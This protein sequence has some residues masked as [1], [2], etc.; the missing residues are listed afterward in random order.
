MEQNLDENHRSNEWLPGVGRTCFKYTY[1]SGPVHTAPFLLWCF[2][3][4]KATRSR[5]SVLY[6]NE[7]KNNRF[8][9]FTLICLIT[10]TEPKI[11][12]FVRSHCS[13]FV[14]LIIGLEAF[15]K[16]SV[17]VRSHWL[18]TFSKTSVFVDIHFWWRFRKPPF[19]WRFCADQCEHFH[20]N[21][22]LP[23]R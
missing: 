18:N 4:T 22:S 13:G 11:S 2:C 10:N 1:I 15:S 6:Q 19:L 12:V 7:E 21:G 20:K 5:Y 14:K 9:A 8:C 16:T 23:L 3:C 17:F